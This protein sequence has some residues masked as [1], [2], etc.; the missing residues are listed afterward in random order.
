[1]T[2]DQLREIYRQRQM[3]PVRS[4]YHRTGM[5]TLPQSEKPSGSS[6]RVVKPLAKYTGGCCGK[7]R[8]TQ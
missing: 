6:V 8:T 7:R 1:M 4:E 3:R 5:I 2:P